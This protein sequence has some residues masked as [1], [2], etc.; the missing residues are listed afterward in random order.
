MN[1][2]D[3]AFKIYM[4]DTGLFVSMLEQGTAA[5]IL[6]GNLGMYKGAVYE[7]I[8]ADAFAK[9]GRELSYFRKDSG[10]EVDFVTRMSGETWLVEVKATTGNAKS[11]KTV[12][13]RPD[14]YGPCC[15]CKLGEYNIGEANGV[16]TLPYYLAF[17]LNG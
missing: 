7:N 14:I 11:L 3:S 17:M 16:L 4:Q 1:K 8:V 10:L 2:V 13:A 12:M 6:S 9:M 5:E 15:A